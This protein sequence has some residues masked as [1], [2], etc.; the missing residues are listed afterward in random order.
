MTPEGLAGYSP[1]SLIPPDGYYPPPALPKG[2]AAWFDRY[3]FVYISTEALQGEPPYYI[4]KDHWDAPLLLPNDQLEY[5]PGR[6]FVA[7]RRQDLTQQPFQIVG[8]SWDGSLQWSKIADTVCSQKRLG[9]QCQ[10]D[11]WLFKPVPW[12]AIQSF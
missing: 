3:D 8:R 2:V 4:V 11:S 5:Y 6:G 7:I 10:T 1:T 12:R 9:A